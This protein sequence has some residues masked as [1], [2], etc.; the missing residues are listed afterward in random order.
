[1][2]AILVLSK[3]MDNLGKKDQERSVLVVITNL[4]LRERERTHHHIKGSSLPTRA[5]C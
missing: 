2:R 3:R 4:L 5:E 1:M